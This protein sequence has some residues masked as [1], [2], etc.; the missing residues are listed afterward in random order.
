MNEIKRIFRP[1]RGFGFVEPLDGYIFSPESYA[2]KFIITQ[3][4][5]V[6]GADTEQAFAAGSTVSCRVLKS[7]QVT[8]L[9]EGTLESGAACVTLPTECYSV[10]GKFLLTILVTTGSTITCVYAAS[11]T[12]IGADSENVNVSE[13]ASRAIDDKIAEINAAAATAQA[14]V[15]QVQAAVAGVPAVIASIPQD[16][17]ALSNSVGDLK[18]AF[19]G[20]KYTVEGGI[21]LGYYPLNYETTVGGFGG[22]VGNTYTETSSQTRTRWTEFVPV[23]KFV[24][25]QFELDDYSTYDYY[26][27]GVDDNN[28]IVYSTGWKHAK[29]AINANAIGDATNG[30]ATK[31]RMMMRKQTESGYTADESMWLHAKVTY[32]PAINANLSYKRVLTEG[33]DLNSFTDP[34]IYYYATSAHPTHEPFSTGAILLVYGYSNT[35]ATTQLA[36]G[37]GSD[38]D[39]NHKMAHR[40]LTSGAWS[41]WRYI[42]QER[43]QK[44]TGKSFSILGDSISSFQ[45]YIPDGY[46]YHYPAG[47]VET[48]TDTW[49]GQLITET[50][51]TLGVNNSYSGSPLCETGTLT[52]RPRGASVTRTSNLGT[53]PD[54]IIIMMGLNDFNQDAS[55]GEYE[56]GDA[57]PNNIND[58]RSALA[59]A[60]H[61]IGN[62][63]P[64]AK[65]LICTIP[66]CYPARLS[67]SAT[68]NPFWT[69]ST[70]GTIANL[71]K[72]IIE[73]CPEF[74]AEVVDLRNLYTPKTRNNWTHDGSAPSGVDYSFGVHPNKGGM[75]KI[76]D[77]IIK[78]L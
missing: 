60:M 54:Y 58:F 65:I 27:I 33:E 18:S 10:P 4:V 26:V 61:D 69:N 48:Y 63:Y 14:A 73:I 11:G 36:I 57:L 13:G 40:E 39:E 31:I 55:V 29:V 71:N 75:T 34:G 67:E 78:H 72:A 7:D 1:E 25:I 9:V 17:T 32:R 45:G 41:E 12:V 42:Q 49:W 20:Y 22:T 38:S 53:N 77:E 2:H 23:S 59:I 76:K 6:N 35:S 37:Y 21:E 8:E 64:S 5:K 3:M 15:S 74:G 24:R 51:M 46:A 16:Y 44:Y 47:S 19:K 68:T 62:N 43:A 52:D 56:I 28:K 50:G 70:T 66:E 30:Y